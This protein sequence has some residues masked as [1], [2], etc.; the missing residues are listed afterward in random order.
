M[1][2]IG[3]FDAEGN[4][5]KIANSNNS[6]F[7]YLHKKASLELNPDLE[8]IEPKYWPAFDEK[9]T[10]YYNCPSCGLPH[11]LKGPSLRGRKAVSISAAQLVRCPSCKSHEDGEYSEGYSTSIAKIKE[12]WERIPDWFFE[13]KSL[14]EDAILTKKGYDSLLNNNTITAS[15]N[16]LFLAGLKLAF[17]LADSD[18]EPKIKAAKHLTKESE[19]KI[20]LICTNLDCQTYNNGIKHEYISTLHLVNKGIYFGCDSCK[21]RG[22]NHSAAELALKKAVEILFGVEHQKT[23]KIKPYHEIDILFNYNGKMFGIEY[24]GKRYHQDPKTLSADESKM[25]IF[26]EKQNI[27]FIRVRE[28]GCLEFSNSIDPAKVI[29]VD[30]WFL[31]LSQEKYL[32]C[33]TQIGQ[34][35]TD[36][37]NYVIPENTIEQLTAI[38]KS[39]KAG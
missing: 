7:K 6:L 28:K 1:S 2:E 12:I 3:G 25:K 27:F 18:K 14:G 8:N 33:L 35:V 26:N 32:K 36:N 22:R 38:A 21:N 4:V 17:E 10:F 39:S 29:E 34:I 11:A 9:R 19:L 31:G 15:S 13:D 24:D 37:P 30:G 20:P 5:A 23:V 16:K